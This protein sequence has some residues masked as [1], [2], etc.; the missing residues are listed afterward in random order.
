MGQAVVSSPLVPVR[1]RQALNVESGLNDGLVLP[2]LL[3]ALA[4]AGAAEQTQTVGHWV[5]FAAMQVTLGPLIGVGVAYVWGASWW[6]A[7]RAPGG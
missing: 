3:I 7:D 2:I 5:L 6:S 4:V 1:I